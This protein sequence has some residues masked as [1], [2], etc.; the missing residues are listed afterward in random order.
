M[1]AA[2]GWGSQAAY[3]R[4]HGTQAAQAKRQAISVEHGCDGPWKLERC[5]GADR[6]GQR[7]FVVLPNSVRSTSSEARRLIE[8]ERARTGLEWEMVRL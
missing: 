1:G 5:T 2:Q 8:D 3:E 6:F 4:V 7:T